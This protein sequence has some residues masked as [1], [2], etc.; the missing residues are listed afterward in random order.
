MTKPDSPTALDLPLVDP[1]PADT[2]KYF[3]IC[4][5][6]LGMVPNV[7]RAHAFD[8]DKLNAFT[9]LYND[10]MLADSGLTKLERE[11]IAVVV[12]SINRCFYCLTAHG[13][14][15][16]EL[17]GDPM[18]GEMLVMNYRVA[19]LDDRTRA[20]LD[21]AARITTASAEIEEPDRQALRDAGFTDRDI[22]DIAN[23]AGFFNMTN[24]VA[25]ATDMRPNE[26]YHA[27]SR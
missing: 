21:F 16:R 4:Q 19:P 10:L 23:V 6:K 26:D 2:Q 3:D 12:S 1:L 13:Q 8:I 9:G 15:V 24:R 5:E 18:L 22:W 17:S 14:A 7:L 25:S 27:R 11:M 20:M